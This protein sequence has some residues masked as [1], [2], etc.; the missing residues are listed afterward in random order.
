MRKIAGSRI[1]TVINGWVQIPGRFPYN[2]A[3]GPG[4]CVRL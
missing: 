4:W 1:L 2:V 3:I